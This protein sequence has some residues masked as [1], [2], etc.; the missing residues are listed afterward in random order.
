M[1]HFSPNFF[2]HDYNENTLKNRQ[3]F[4]KACLTADKI[5]DAAAQKKQKRCFIATAAYMSEDHPSVISLRDFRDQKLKKSLL[6]NLFVE[7][8]YIVS[9]P[10]AK[11]IDANPKARNLTVRALD[12]LVK[13]I[14]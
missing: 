12:K 9:P 6:G 3:N 8:Y 10:I 5:L 13:K 11:L 4:I 14:S 2:V 1:T 7:T